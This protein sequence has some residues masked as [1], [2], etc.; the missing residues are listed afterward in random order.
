[1]GSS[2]NLNDEALDRI[3]Y[4]QAVG[5]LLYLT[6]C[7]RPDLEFAVN[8]VSRF[9]SNYRMAHWQAVKRI[10][11]KRQSTVAVSTA[12]AEYV[13]LAEAVK[14]AMWLQQLADELDKN[15]VK[16]ITINCDSQSAIN[17]SESDGF[18]RR[19]KHIDVRHHFIREKIQ[20]GIVKVNFVPGTEMT[21]DYLTKAVPKE[22]HQFCVQQSGLC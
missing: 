18:N 16:S 11:S 10:M 12:E 17:L 9:N 15:S 7:T 20:S 5:C 4:Q 3:P 22:K 1:M 19:T 13:S 2:S 8:E 14:E 21:A 6:Q